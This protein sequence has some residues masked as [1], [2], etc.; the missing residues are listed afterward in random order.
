MR[1][2]YVKIM[3]DIKNRI[4]DSA[5]EITARKEEMIIFY[6]DGKDK[7]LMA[8]S[9]SDGTVLGNLFRTIGNLLDSAYKKS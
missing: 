6:N 5:D 9:D 8:M 4:Q 3:T 7:P 2:S 1:P